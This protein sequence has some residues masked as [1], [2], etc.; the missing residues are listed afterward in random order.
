ML[1]R[2][3]GDVERPF[4]LV[5]G[6]AKVDDK[7]GVLVNLGARADAVLVGGKMA[8]ELRDDESAPVRRRPAASTSSQPPAFEPDAESRVDPLRRAAGRLARPRHRSRDA[9]AVRRGDRA[10]RTVFWNGPMGVFEWPRFADGTRAVAAGRRRRG[11]VHR[12]R[13]RATRCARSTELGLADRVGGCRPGRRLARAARGQGA[14]GR[15][16]DPGG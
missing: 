16:R 7:L 5:A 1:G 11:C 6:G 12:R 2:L 9:R 13:R 3:L 10:A 15:R 8:E 4:V 14:A